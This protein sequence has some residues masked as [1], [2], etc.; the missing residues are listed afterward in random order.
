MFLVV[1]FFGIC[2]FMCI[3]YYCRQHRCLQSRLQQFVT[4]NIGVAQLARSTAALSWTVISGAPSGPSVKSV[5]P[6]L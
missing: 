6:L 5:L 2:M 4:V 1:I 3:L